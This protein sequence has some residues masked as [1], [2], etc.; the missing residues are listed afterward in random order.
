MWL[1]VTSLQPFCVAL[2]HKGAQ[3]QAFVAVL[4]IM[5]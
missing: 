2:L 1:N 3:L 4:D 5:V